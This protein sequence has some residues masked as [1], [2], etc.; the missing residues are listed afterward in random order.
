V[1]FRSLSECVQMSFF[2]L[3]D[4]LQERLLSVMHTFFDPANDARAIQGN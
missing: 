4:C 1:L 2:M 3:V